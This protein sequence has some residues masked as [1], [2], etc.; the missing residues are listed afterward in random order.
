MVK[1]KIKGNRK[2]SIIIGSIVSLCIL[3]SVYFGISAYFTNRFYYGS[4]INCIS[5]SGKTVKEVDNQISSEVENYVLE[6]KE[7]GDKKEQISPADIA[8]KYN[9][10]GQ[11]KEIKDKQNPLKWVSAFFNI[12]DFKVKRLVSYDEEL[13]K[14]TI[15]NLSC[16]NSSNIVEPED[17][18]IKY[19]DA[20]YVIVDEVNGNKIKKDVLYE[21]VVKAILEG[22]KTIDLE[23]INCYE[24]PKYTS[25][26]QELVD[27]KNTL[28]KYIATKVTYTFGS[29]TEVLDVSTINNW[30]KVDDN[31]AVTLDEGKVK[32]YLDKLS[33]TYNT[34]GKTRELV[35]SLGTTVKVSGGDYGWSINS[36]KEAQELISDIKE[37]KVTTKQPIYSQTALTREGNDLGKT[38]VEVNMTKQHLWF[39]KNGS[40]IVEG[41]IVTGNV[42]E[43]NATPTG[44]YKLKYKQKDATLRGVD[45]ATPVEF[46]MPF[47]GGVGI[48]DATWRDTFGG[49]IYMASGSHGCVNSPYEVA[50]TIFYN[51]QEGTP[52]ICFFE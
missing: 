32:G 47:N 14:K 5:V 33:Q 36:N 19:A 24:N 26:S 12:N 41:D 43:N 39:Y 40:L 22:E 15:D 23:A 11:V 13:L 3:T 27:A 29:R 45:Y 34:I 30:V 35:T 46:W 25:K 50:K 2:K 18:S 4:T 48:H 44:I 37:G 8:L 10:E 21:K 7:R 17:A 1:L 42:S 28:N 20:G 38:Y 9:S 49:D 16:F 6:L 52:I 31:F 51:I